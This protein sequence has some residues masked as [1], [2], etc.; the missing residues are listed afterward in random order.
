VTSLRDPFNPKTGAFA[1]NIR[2]ADDNDDV[3]LRESMQR[4]GWSSEFP[5]LIDE[6]GVVLVGHRRLNIAKELGIRP[7]VKTLALGAGDAAD[8]ERLKLALV[9]NIGSKPLTKDDRKRI[10][11]H[12]Y[13]EKEWTMERIA[14]A[15]NVSHPTITRDLK[16]FVHDEQNK[17]RGRGR[18]KG[19]GISGHPVSTDRIYRGAEVPPNPKLAAAA[20]ELPPLTMSAQQKLEAWQRQYK[21]KLDLEFR[22]CVLDEVKKRIDE[23]ILPHWKE[24]IARAEELY[25][26][27]RGAMDKA[28]FNKIRRALHPDSRNSISDKMLGEAFDTFMSL[29]KFLLDE[30]DSPTDLSGLPNTW[31]EWEKAKKDATAE[32][33]ARRA[34]GHSSAV[35]RT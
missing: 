9:S 32:R 26:H 23:M 6:N 5:A 17:P 21:R 34:K 7:V 2:V 8:A 12:L 13:G 4:F 35:R 27:R 10:A 11:E 33:R 14:E 15:L 16:D 22:T 19:S 3:E 18:P 30:K 28:T 20:Q 24:K 25:K 1:D 31:D 29:E